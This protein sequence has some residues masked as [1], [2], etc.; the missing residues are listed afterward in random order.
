MSEF[1][2]VL[3]SPRGR[4]QAY[5]PQPASTLALARGI[6]DRAPASGRRLE[7]VIEVKTEAGWERYE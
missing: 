6:R 7:P 1:R 4:V 3:Y 2:V 5:I